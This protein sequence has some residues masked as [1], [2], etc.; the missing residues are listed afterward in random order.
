MK[1]T[2]LFL[3]AA[4]VALVACNKTEFTGPESDNGEAPVRFRVAVSNLTKLNGVFQGTNLPETENIP[5]V[6]SIHRADGTTIAPKA[7]YEYLKYLDSYWYLADNSGNISFVLPLGDSRLDVLA[8]YSYL[9][10][11]HNA[12]MSAAEPVFSVN[13]GLEDP[14]LSAYESGWSNLN[15]AIWTPFYADKD[16]YANKVYYVNVDTPAYNYDLMFGSANDIK[17]GETKELVLQHA[18]AAVYFNMSIAN[19][20]PNQVGIDPPLFINPGD[21]SSDFYKALVDVST[22]ERGEN[23]TNNKYDSYLIDYY[24]DYLTLKTVGTFVIDNSKNN[25][26]A[27]WYL[28]NWSKLSN[29]DTYYDSINH[30]QGFSYLGNFIEENSINSGKDKR[31]IDMSSGYIDNYFS[32]PD[33]YYQVCSQ[34]IPEQPV[35]NPWLRYWIGGKIYLTEINLPR[36]TWQ[37]GHAYIYNL[38]LNFDGVKFTVTVD[39][40]KTIMHGLVY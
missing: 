3:A 36:G 9:E 17:K 28:G 32:D 5:I 38:K 22:Y 11:K 7:G 26:E 2:I 33:V 23:I 13:G 21:P 40:Y 37:R 30:G 31:E 20:L 10:G 12:S 6:S 39:D 34:L 14:Y 25:L 15:D 29:W 16:N 1:K 35:V 19:N 8:T 18:M 4:A 27:Y 24:F